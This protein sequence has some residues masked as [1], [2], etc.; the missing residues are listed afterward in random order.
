MRLVYSSAP[1]DESLR[2]QLASHLHPFV[3]KEGITE[4]HEQLI[5]PGAD[6]AQAR[7][8]AWRAADALILLLSA[9]YFLSEACDADEIQYALARRQRGQLLIIP[10]LL[11]PCDW[12]S[13]RS[14]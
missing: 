6:I 13:T 11:R 12:Q 10:V 7:R 1:A 9:D 2:T 8:A 3:Q 5:P 4:W 14:E